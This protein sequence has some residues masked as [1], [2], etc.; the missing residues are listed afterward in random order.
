VS[1]QASY[2][3]SP[4]LGAAPAPGASVEAFGVGILYTFS[5][6]IIGPPNKSPAAPEPGA[7]PPPT[8]PPHS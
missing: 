5:A 8:P 4:P 1:V 7:P 2:T 3:G 6:K